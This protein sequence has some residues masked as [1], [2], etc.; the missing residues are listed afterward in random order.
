MEFLSSKLQVYK[1]QTSALSV[2]ETPENSWDNMCCA[3]LFY[4][5][6]DSPQS[7]S[8]NIFL[9]NSQEGLEVCTNGRVLTK[10]QAAFFLEQE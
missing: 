8:V 6:R 7:I 3:G 1:L 9:E 10:F 5:L 2:F 4:T